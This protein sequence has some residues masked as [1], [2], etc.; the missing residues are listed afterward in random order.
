MVPFLA[1]TC[2]EGSKT[3]ESP[4]RSYIHARKI[5]GKGWR[6]PKAEKREEERSG[7]YMPERV[8]EILTDESGNFRRH[9][10]MYLPI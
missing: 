2:Q 8:S 7:G 6:K 5:T 10:L 4:T 3:N 9:Y 1:W